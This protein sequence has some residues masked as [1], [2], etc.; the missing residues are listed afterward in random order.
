MIVHGKLQPQNAHYG[1][2]G[3]NTRS[4]LPKK[5]DEK[6][7]HQVSSHGWHTLLHVTRWLM[8]Q[9]IVG[10]GYGHNVNGDDSGEF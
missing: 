7:S 6:M 1:I 9:I 2:N 5:N 10:C 8:L 4:Y 3:S